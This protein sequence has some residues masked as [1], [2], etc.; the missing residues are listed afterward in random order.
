[1]TK[2]CGK[3]WS[4]PP[5]TSTPITSE[6]A[7]FRRLSNE[8]TYQKRE[9]GK[10]GNNG[11]NGKLSDRIYRIV[12]DWRQR[13]IF[14]TFLFILKNHVHPVYAFPYVPIFP[15]FP[16]FPYSLFKLISSRAA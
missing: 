12:Q 8:T 14:H 15:S 2:A 1:M 10:D 3:R 7:C 9:Y 16:S 11:T 6:G 4:K 5:E 13:I